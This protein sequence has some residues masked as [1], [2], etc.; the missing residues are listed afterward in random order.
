MKFEENYKIVIKMK[1]VKFDVIHCNFE[2]PTL[3]LIIIYLKIF[4]YKILK[5]S[6]EIPTS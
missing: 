3:F 4:F 2:I 5:S 6:F 1:V